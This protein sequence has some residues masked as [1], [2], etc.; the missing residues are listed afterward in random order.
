MVTPCW[1][2]NGDRYPPFLSIPEH[3]KS[4]SNVITTTPTTPSGTAA[5][6]PSAFVGCYFNNDNICNHPNAED[7]CTNIWLPIGSR[8]N[9]MIVP[10]K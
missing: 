6:F 9:G 8:N 4:S 5:S 1:E 7:T 2:E 10:M 3:C